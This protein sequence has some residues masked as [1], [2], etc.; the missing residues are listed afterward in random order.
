MSCVL[1]AKA[2]QLYCATCNDVLHPDECEYISLCN[3]N[4][5][6]EILLNVTLRFYLRFFVI[7]S[8]VVTKEI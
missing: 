5:V 2:N 7:F 3:E 6:S 8:T 4:D 1:G